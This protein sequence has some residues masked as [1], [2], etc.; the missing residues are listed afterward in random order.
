MTFGRA[1]LVTLLLVG[2]S[3][4][5]AKDGVHTREAARIDI[6]A[7]ARRQSLHI[8][9]T[10]TYAATFQELQADTW[11]LTPVEGSTLTI[12]GA[13][14]AKEYCLSVVNGKTTQTY[15]STEGQQGQCHLPS[16]A[17]NA[18]TYQGLAPAADL[19]K[20]A[21]ALQAKAIDI[22]VSGRAPVNT[23]GP[24]VGI[25]VELVWTDG[26]GGYCLKAVSASVTRIYDSYAGGVQP[27]GGAC[28]S[29]TVR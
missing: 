16:S 21:R 14:G 5:P 25:P 28:V 1:T 26:V 3:N 19:A 17:R 24:V 23:L 15:D 8:A 11:P 13:D 27:Q 4:T 22:E 18:E 20:V 12:L 10:G 6:N 7:I 9:H 2:C 29:S